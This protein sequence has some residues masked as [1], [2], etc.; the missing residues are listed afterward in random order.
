MSSEHPGEQAA[1]PPKA[2]APPR[3]GV[4]D[5]TAANALL[6][7]EQT[8]TR[9]QWTKLRVHVLRAERLLEADRHLDALVELYAAEDLEIDLTGDCQATADIT[10]AVLG[11]LGLDEEDV[12]QAWGQAQRQK[13]HPGERRS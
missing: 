6:D 2:V 4:P 1:E 7:E 12:Y 5:F 13:R 3:E 10:T 11:A 8:E 9:V